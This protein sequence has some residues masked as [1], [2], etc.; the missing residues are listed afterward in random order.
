MDLRFSHFGGYCKMIIIAG[1][2]LYAFACIKMIMS[3]PWYFLRRGE[4][5]LAGHVLVWQYVSR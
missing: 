2:N 5:E 3:W 4:V 1:N